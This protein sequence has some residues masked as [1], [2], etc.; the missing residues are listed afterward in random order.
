MTNAKEMTRVVALEMALELAKDNALLSEKLEKMLET[1]RKLASRK[2]GES[3]TTKEKKANMEKV[4]QAFES[5]ENTNFKTLSEI[6]AMIG[7][8]D[9]SSQKISAIM[10]PLVEQG[11]FEKGLTN[12][13]VSFRKK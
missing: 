4:C 2:R 3:K 11:L 10:K 13:K 6:G 5:V 8:E 1:E 12:K 7:L 9:A